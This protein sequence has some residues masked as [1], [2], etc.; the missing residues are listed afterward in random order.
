MLVS[1]ELCFERRGRR[2][3]ARP[4]LLSSPLWDTC[5]GGKRAGWRTGAVSVLHP[6]PLTSLAHVTSQSLRKGLNPVPALS[7]CLAA[8]GCAHGVCNALRTCWEQE[9]ET[10]VILP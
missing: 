5:T 2:V 6:L 4:G 7:S 10:S 1:G 3:K 8:M 9:S